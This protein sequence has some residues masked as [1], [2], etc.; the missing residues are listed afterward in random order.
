MS[1]RARAQRKRHAH[2]HH[3]HRLSCLPLWAAIHMLDASRKRKL[4]QGRDSVLVTETTPRAIA[5]GGGVVPDAHDP[6][7]LDVQVVTD[8]RPG[9]VDAPCQTD[10][11]CGHTCASACTSEF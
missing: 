9:E 2:R 11:G 6:F 3:A 10:D 4:D 5:G 7:A 8:T 1:A